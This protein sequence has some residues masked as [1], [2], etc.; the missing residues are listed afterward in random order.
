MKLLED[1]QILGLDDEEKLALIYNKINQVDGI[2]SN[3]D[4]F[5][6]K[7]GNRNIRILVEYVFALIEQDYFEP[8][9]MHSY[10]NEASF[11]ARILVR[12]RNDIKE[13]RTKNR[14]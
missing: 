13:L 5:N 6:K 3:A 8:D 9:K 7:M 14:K 1:F 11:K 4:T 2:L 10:S 12:I